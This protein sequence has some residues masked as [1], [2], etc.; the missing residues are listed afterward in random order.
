MRRLLV[1]CVILVPWLV[2][3]VGQAQLAPQPLPGRVPMHSV[4]LK[5]S[6][7]WNA[8]YDVAPEDQ[9]ALY[10]T[11]KALLD[12]AREQLRNTQELDK[13]VKALEDELKV[14]REHL[15]MLKSQICDP[16]EYGVYMGVQELP[17][18][19]GGGPKTAELNPEVFKP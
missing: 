11:I 14:L 16:N 15:Q 9:R 13:R 12:A 17:V 8:Y 2:V 18:C 10:W 5:P 7:E 1:G 19:I 4:L 3:F 6:A